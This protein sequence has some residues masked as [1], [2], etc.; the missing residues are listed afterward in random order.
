[1]CSKITL[2]PSFSQQLCLGKPK[3]VRIVREQYLR[4][5]IE[6]KECESFKLLAKE[7]NSG[8][9]YFVIDYD[10]T[11]S[12][13]ELFETSDLKNIIFLQTVALEV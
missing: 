3:V 2:W 7:R 8:E 12:F 1:M 13:L 4:K 9:I 6:T 5:D 10:V 11:K